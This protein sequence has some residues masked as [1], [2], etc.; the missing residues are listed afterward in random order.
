MYKDQITCLLGHNGAG[1]TTLINILTGLILPTKGT[2]KILGMVCI[3]FFHLQNLLV[4]LDFGPGE[5]LPSLG[6]RRLL[7]VVCK[8]FTF[9]ASSPKPFGFSQFIS[10]REEDL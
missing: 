2:A 9:Q 4:H 7:S 3:D 6:I 8:L 1:K 10:F 5:L